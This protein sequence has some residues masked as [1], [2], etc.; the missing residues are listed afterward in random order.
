MA[1]ILLPTL[2]YPPRT[3][4]VARYLEAIK[5]T[6]GDDMDVLFFDDAPGRLSMLWTL[7]KRSRSYEQA[8][9]SHILPIGT[10]LWL[11]R[12]RYS[13]F[14]HGMDFDLARR[15]AWKRWLTRRILR[16]AQHVFANSHA[17]ASEIG[18]FCNRRVEVVYPCVSDA[19]VEASN[20][21]RRESHEGVTLLTV[22]RLVERKGHMD[23]LEI[24]RRNN[25]LKYVIVGDGPMRKTI[26]DFVDEHEL[27]DR[28]ELLQSV[29]DRKLPSIY[30]RAD[31]F[32]MP[33][34]KSEG[35][36][37][38]FGIVYLE[39]QL[40]GTPVIAV[41]HPGV[42]EAVVEGVGGLLINSH[43]DLDTAVKKLVN[44]RELR[45]Q[46]GRRGQEFVKAK[47]TRE[48]QF[49]ALRSYIPS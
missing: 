8:W 25:D 39:A 15:S 49:S 31:I 16:R 37:E 27:A 17:L 18:S 35:D 28:V 5:Q 3:G 21:V 2:D 36:R 1:K 9:T 32:V 42:N 44:G 26:E 4:G 23:M 10:M 29:P 41:S 38:G 47:F 46:L 34:H 12:R 48:H 24:V 6:L 20:V 19:F 30:A 33:T 13:V 7:W 43:E 22:G 45:E 40:F 11:L 14:L